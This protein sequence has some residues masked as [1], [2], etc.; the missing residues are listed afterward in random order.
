MLG[1][2]PLVD[3]D[4]AWLGSF[5]LVLRDEELLG[6]RSLPFSLRCLRIL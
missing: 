2:S 4:A 1:V 5:L 3:D 6:L